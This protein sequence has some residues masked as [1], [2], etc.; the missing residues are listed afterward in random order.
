MPRQRRGTH[1]RR[2]YRDGQN[3]TG[4]KGPEKHQR[5]RHSLAVGALTKPTGAPAAPVARSAAISPRQNGGGEGRE[6]RVLAAKI[7]WAGGPGRASCRYHGSME[8]ESRLVRGGPVGTWMSGQI[9]GPSP[10]PGKKK[11]L[12]TYED[13][14]PKRPWA[15]LALHSTCPAAIQPQSVVGPALAPPRPISLDRR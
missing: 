9:G 14:P 5:Q 1:N 10:R 3:K 11:G 13:L 8:G 7:A 12:S 15:L 2:W 6:G 4:E